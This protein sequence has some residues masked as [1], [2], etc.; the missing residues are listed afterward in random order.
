ML[1][2]LTGLAGAGKDTVADI[3]VEKHGF[4]KLAFGTELKRVLS[5]MNPV[6]GMDIHSPGRMIH[7]N[8]ALERF[9]EPGVK[10]VYPLYRKYLQKFGTEG[11]RSID[12]MFW[13]KATLKDVDARARNY[14][15][16]DVRFP[17]EA[18]VI[19]NLRGSLWQVERPGQEIIAS[20]H[21][22]ESWAG[23]M[24]EDHLIYNSGSI[25]RLPVEVQY[26]LGMTYWK[27]RV[28]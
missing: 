24:G 21:G 9:G 8:E 15:I 27:N 18:E 25:D 12:D 23:K 5:V 20:F 4:I 14:V 6:I 26:A 17:N 28:A 7:L 13:I 2:G 16:T 19:G 22:S 11:I 3:L 10:K 1:I